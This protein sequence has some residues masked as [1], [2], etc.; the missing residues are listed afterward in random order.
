MDAYSDSTVQQLIGVDNERDG[1]LWWIHQ[2]EKLF[3]QMIES[4]LNCKVIWPERMLNGD[5][6]QVHEMLDWVGLS[7]NTGI[8]SILEE[9]LI[10]SK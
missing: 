4:G 8:I 6:R 9:Q 5:F 2:Q 1:W 7:W 3:V 10:K